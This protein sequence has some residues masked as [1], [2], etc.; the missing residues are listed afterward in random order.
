MRRSS[1]V[2][3]R[4]RAAATLTFLLAV[5]A[6]TV[7]STNVMRFASDRDILGYAIALEN[8]DAESPEKFA[9]FLS[10]PR[11]GAAVQGCSDLGSRARL[12][13]ALAGFDTFAPAEP[14]KNGGDGFAA[15]AIA[16]AA[17]RLACNPLDGAA[18]LQLARLRL[19]AGAPLDAVAADLR[20]SYL[21]APSED[22][23]LEARLDFLMSPAAVDLAKRMEAN[24]D[25]D[26]RTF[27]GFEPIPAIAERFMRSNP[28]Y[29]AQL[30][31]M[32]DIQPD[33]RRAAIRVKID[34]LSGGRQL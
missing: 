19:R 22:W 4:D 24:L 15:H 21:L 2:K 18:W 16:A 9:A 14:G 31:N 6:A 3:L 33:D 23:I 1:V 20:L 11:S 5:L 34:Q 8:G 28:T 7:A 26:L 10:D 13:I 32:I 25:S 12:A 27:V 29:Q 17:A 30:K